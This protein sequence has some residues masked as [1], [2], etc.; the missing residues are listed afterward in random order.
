MFA[1][2][3]FWAQFGHSLKIIIRNLDLMPHGI[4]SL[5]TNETFVPKI[6]LPLSKI[7]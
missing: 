1:I 5:L 6:K 7:S 4:L 2:R 3:S